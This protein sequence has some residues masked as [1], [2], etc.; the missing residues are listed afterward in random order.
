LVTV[1]AAPTQVARG[2]RKAHNLD[3]SHGQNEL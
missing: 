1:D 3:S 2:G